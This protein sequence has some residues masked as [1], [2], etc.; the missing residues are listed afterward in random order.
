MRDL[1]EKLA[2]LVSELPEDAFNALSDALMGSPEGR[3][4]TEVAANILDHAADSAERAIGG[5]MS[6]EEWVAKVREGA[7]RLRGRVVGAAR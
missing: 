6:L 3:M 5:G 4:V 1:D 2:A 7:E